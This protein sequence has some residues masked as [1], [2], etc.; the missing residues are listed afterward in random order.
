MDEAQGL[1]S[2]YELIEL[3]RDRLKE[4]AVQN[5]SYRAVLLNFPEARL[6]LETMFDMYRQAEPIRQKVET[7]FRDLDSLIQLI[8]ETLDLAEVH[9]LLEQHPPSGLVH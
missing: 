5:A 1:K 9:R 7:G 2:L 4:C 3:L 6:H 8:S